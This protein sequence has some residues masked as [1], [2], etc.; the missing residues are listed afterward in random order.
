MAHRA[1][2][3]SL[4]PDDPNVPKA[5]GL[6]RAI[7]DAIHGEDDRLAGISVTRL[8]T[9]LVASELATMNVESSLNF[10]DLNDGQGDGIVIVGGEMVQYDARGDTTFTTLARGLEGSTVRE[11]HPIGTLVYDFAQNRSALDH[12]RRGFLVRF[13][14]GRDL[15]VV[16]RNLGL[17]KCFGL[18]DDQWRE[19]IPRVAYMP[20]QTLDSMRLVL[21]AVFP[22]QYELFKLI[23][24]PYRVR[25]RVALD[26]SGTL[27]GKFFLNGMEFQDTTGLLE[28]ETDFDINQVLSVYDDTALT[29]LGFAGP[30]N[31]FTGGSFAGTTIT[32]GSSPG[33][34]GTPVLVNYGAFKAHYLAEDFDVIQDAD[35]YAYLSDDTEVVRCLLDMV[36][37][38]GIKVEVGLQGGGTPVFPPPLP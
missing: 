1:P 38:A 20:R 6:L 14:V 30:T 29:R 16:G 26:P 37:A 11:V 32:L 23:S 31:Y 13:A 33:A 35:Q 36:R 8:T 10:G 28:V 25:A 17:S 19:V 22:G 21:D 9:P 5:S 4:M 7:L 34:V 27:D 15:D 2:T 12:V 3:A 18:T 24:E